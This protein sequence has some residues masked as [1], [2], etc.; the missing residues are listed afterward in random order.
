MNLVI[1]R[2]THGD[3]LTS[4]SV[5]GAEKDPDGTIHINTMNGD[6]RVRLWAPRSAAYDAQPRSGDAGLNPSAPFAP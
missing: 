6:Y 5:C 3:T 4:S 2:N 1:Y